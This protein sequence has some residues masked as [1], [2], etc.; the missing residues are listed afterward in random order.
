MNFT[1]ILLILVLL[2]AL[3]VA[4]VY[5]VRHDRGDLNSSPYRDLIAM[6]KLPYEQGLRLRGE[7]RVPGQDQF[8]QAMVFYASDQ[9]KRASGLLRQALKQQP[10]SADWWLY[11]GICLFMTQDGKDAVTALGRARDQGEAAT[12]N[13]A[14]WF[15][16]QCRL[17]LGERDAAEQILDRL[18]SE[19]SSYAADARD[20]LLR[21]RKSDPSATAGRPMINS[22]TGGERYLTG[23]DIAVRWS[24]A[25]TPSTRYRVL[26]ST[27]DGVTFPTTLAQGIA[28]EPMEWAWPTSGVQGKHLRLR[29][30]AVSPDSTILGVISEAFSCIVAPLIELTGPA[31][32]TP[33]RAGLD[34]AVAWRVVG[35]APFSYR[36][37]VE[38]PG[39]GGYEQDQTV[40]WSIDGAE[41][42]TD[43]YVNSDAG[44]GYRLR[45]SAQFTDTALA[46]VSKATY[47]VRPAVAV[48]MAGLD[49]APESGW[50]PGMPLKV[51]WELNGDQ[52]RGY[53]IELCDSVGQARKILAMNLAGTLTDWT[54]DQADARGSYM[55]KLTAHYAEGDLV[56]FVSGSTTTP[57]GIESGGGPGTASVADR[58]GKVPEAVELEQNYPNPFNST[59]MIRFRL[60]QSGPVKLVVYNTL[61]QLVRTLADETMKAGNHA[62]SCDATG[63][64][65]GAY[66]YSLEAAGQK[67][68][69]R[70]VLVK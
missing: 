18:V 63:L 17:L 49:D 8:D 1:K 55:L 37:D 25:S 21:L 12:Q 3:V 69:K 53:T 67:Q 23:R 4:A 15:L 61:G 62:V 68:Q 65:S 47:E 56:K 70:M 59:T 66:I 51:A 64:A 11:Y 13:H 10:D 45:L 26:L 24:F 43:W 39:G 9:F 33:L 2:G 54:W 29:V 40:S 41:R 19:K 5:F 42:S 30:D 22:P 52:P 31:E 48:Y 20:M 57:S 34:Y 14:R 38:K 50:R 6:R 28:A 35:D 7:A 60:G 36:L 27:D 44:T 46:I 58:G 32:G 16:A